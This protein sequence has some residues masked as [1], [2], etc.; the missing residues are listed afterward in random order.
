MQ[1]HAT[2]EIDEASP[3]KK[4]DLKSQTADTQDQDKELCFLSGHE[5]CVQDSDHTTSVNISSF[6]SCFKI[7]I[8][9][10]HILPELKYV[11]V[12]L[13]HLYYIIKISSFQFLN[14][15]LFG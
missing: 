12:A 10:Q 6:Q 7:T 5:M 13:C 3:A 8:N 14:N 9:E 4:Q 11:T 15:Y 2:L 1:D